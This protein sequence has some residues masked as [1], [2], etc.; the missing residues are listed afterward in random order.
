[1]ALGELF[2]LSKLTIQAFIDAGRPA[3]VPELKVQFNPETLSLRHEAVF[4]SGYQSRKLKYL[5]PRAKTLNVALVVDGTQVGMMG[6]EQLLPQPTVAQRVQQFLDTCNAASDQQRDTS[7]LKLIWD[8]G[9]LGIG[10]FACRMQSVD[11]RYSAFHRDGSPLRAE[12][13]AVFLEHLGASTLAAADG[14]QS[15]VVSSIDTLPQLCL[16]IYGSAAPYLL[17]AKANGLNNFRALSPG[18]ALIFPPLT[19]AR[20]R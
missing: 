4:Q 15:R 2:Q 5:H 3:A 1:M 13:T 16:A 7:H 10:G 14:A 6:V 9:V 11:I 20:R 19:G 17:V 8:K 12:L 18:Q